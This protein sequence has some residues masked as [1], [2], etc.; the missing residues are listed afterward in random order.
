M[1]NAAAGQKVWVSLNGG[2]HCKFTDGTTICDV[3]SSPGSISRSRQQAL[4]NRYTTAFFNFYLKGDTNYR[5]FLCG[6]SIRWDESNNVL[7][8]QSN[9]PGCPP[10][11][12][13]A[14]LQDQSVFAVYPN[15]NAGKLRIAGDGEVWV[16]DGLGR[17]L[18]SL[19]LVPEHEHELELPTGVYWVK[20]LKSGRAQVVQVAR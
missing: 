16:M 8:F 9:V 10:V 17:R 7:T 4:S 11:V 20:E 15:P 19:S 18:H 13:V 5:A 14:Q 3:V 2:A 6:D 12:S 1:Y